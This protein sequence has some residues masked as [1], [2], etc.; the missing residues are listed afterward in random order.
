MQEYLHNNLLATWQIGDADYLAYGRVYRNQTK[1][2]YIPEVFIGGNDYQEVLLDDRVAASSFFGVENTTEFNNF[3][4]DAQV[5]VVFWVDLSRLKSGTAQRQDEEVHIDVLK[6]VN[7]IKKFNFELTG[8]ETGIDTIFRNY[9]GFRVNEAIKYRDM[10][11]F[12][13]FRLNFNLNYNNINNC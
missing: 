7:N 13:C 8:I 9:S 2:G 1:D 12:H 3:L 10:H 11:P 6:L 5:F 4:V